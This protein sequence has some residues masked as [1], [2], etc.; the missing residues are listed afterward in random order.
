MSL[1]SYIFFFF[2][3]DTATTEIYTLSL[4]DAL[5]I[6]DTVTAPALPAGWVAANSTGPAPL[7]VTSSLTSDTPPNNAFIDDPATVSDKHL[8]TPGIAITSGLA[9]V[10]FRSFYNLESGF[11][12][13]VLEVSSPNIAGGAFTDVTN[14]AVGGSFE[15]G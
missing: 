2:F 15:S 7:W 5:P 14:A 8:D 6:F 9:E 10:S 1:T 11:D 4:H 13:G 12:G 3:N